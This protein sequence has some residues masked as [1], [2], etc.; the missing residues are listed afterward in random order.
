MGIDLGDVFEILKNERRRRIIQFL[1]TH[2]DHATTTGALAE[3]LAALENDVPVSRVSSSQRKRVYVALYQCHLPKLDHFGVVDF[4][5]ERGA[6]KLLDTS[7]FDQYLADTEDG[8]D[9]D[10]RTD[11]L[12]GVTVAVIVA[13]GLTGI[14]ALS[15]VP[16]VF[17]TLV[18]V[19]AL[20]W[21]VVT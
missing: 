14:G 2:E 13:I 20:L 17:W 4:D 5:K 3:H 21:V 10:D 7:P 9:G 11:R 19:A 15:T 16:V 6:I 18:S 8:D 1:K 12:V